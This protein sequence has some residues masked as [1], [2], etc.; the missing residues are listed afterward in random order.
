[1]APHAA[2][3]LASPWLSQLRQF[4][5]PSCVPLAVYQSPLVYRYSFYFSYPY[6]HVFASQS[7]TNGDVCESNKAQ[8]LWVLK[9]CLWMQLQVFLKP[10]L[11]FINGAVVV[12]QQF[13][14]KTISHSH[15]RISAWSPEIS[16]ELYSFSCLA[17]FSRHWPCAIFLNLLRGVLWVL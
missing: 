8:G 3:S 1:M 16:T 10:V 14:N 15:I 12:I 4:I 6:S 2:I 11:L 9:K 5:L 13:G 7:N 17:S